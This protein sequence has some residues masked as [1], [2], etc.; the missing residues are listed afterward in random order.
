MGIEFFSS[1]F[2]VSFVFIYLS[3]EQRSPTWKLK[4][5]KNVK[6][7][8]LQTIGSSDP[9]TS[10]KIHL[11]MKASVAQLTE[12]LHY[13]FLQYYGKYD[14]NFKEGL[15]WDGEGS[16]HL[17]FHRKSQGTFKPTNSSII[18]FPFL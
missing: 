1:F 18:V 17:K 9:N 10:I 5:A 11:K 8:K 13:H 15:N 2:L 16:F 6:A 4:K 14:P 12:I 7:F 3:I